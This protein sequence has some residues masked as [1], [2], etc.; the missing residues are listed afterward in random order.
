MLNTKNN[1]QHSKL[2][3]LFIPLI[4]ILSCILW[5]SCEDDHLPLPEESNAGIESDNYKLGDKQKCLMPNVRTKI[6]DGRLTF[7]TIEDM[8]LYYKGLAEKVNES[9][10]PDEVM[11]CFEKGYS[12]LRPI[13][14]NEENEFYSRNA[15]RK[16]K[17]KFNRG[18]IKDDI[19]KSMLNEYYEVGVGSDVYI[20]MTQDQV[21]KTSCDSEI[22]KFRQLEK[23][24]DDKIHAEVFYSSGTLFK[25]NKIVYQGTL[26]QHCGNTDTGGGTGGNDDDVL[27]ECETYNSNANVTSGDPCDIQIANLQ[28]LNQAVPYDCDSGEAFPDQAY[29]KNSAFDINWGDGSPVQ[30]VVGLDPL[31]QHVY[32]TGS[33]SFTITITGTAVDDGGNI[34]P[35][36]IDP[37][38]FTPS[39]S[40]FTCGSTAASKTVWKHEF[41]TNPTPPAG[42][43]GMKCEIWHTNDVIGSHVGAKT[44]GKRW[45][46]SE[47]ETEK[48]EIKVQINVTWIDNDNDDDNDDPCGT[49]DPVQKNDHCDDCKDKKCHSSLVGQ[50]NHHVDKGDSPPVSLHEFTDNGV[51]ITHSLTIHQCTP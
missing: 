35:L 36:D 40:T 43:R 31:V 8:W 34:H 7:I 5:I 9:D 2:I 12:S 28:L 49:A 16:T 37:Q 45:N 44:T 22:M 10:S 50:Y 30:S 33:S 24:L 38:T 4:L 47:W 21:L 20:F 23:G 3:K 51:T 48:G 46:G 17:E 18:F 39:A 42:L 41:T 11:A 29:R 26:E 25:N 14:E 13:I 1:K 15:F 32:P 19:R 27:A 6:V